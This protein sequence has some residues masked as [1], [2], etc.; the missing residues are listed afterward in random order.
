MYLGAV[1]RKARQ[2]WYLN[3]PHPVVMLLGILVVVA[4]LSYVLPAGEY[5][6][7]LVAGR[8]RVVPGSFRFVDARPVGLLTLFRALPEGFAKAAP[9]VYVI[10]ASGIM[11]G[12]VEQTGAIERAVC[13]LIRSVG[14]ARRLQVLV[15]T[16]FVYGMLGVFVGYEN[17]I[18]MVPIAAVLVLA[19]GGDLL[20]A[21]GVSVGAITVGFGVSPFNPY[22]VGIGHQLAQLP[23]FSGWLLRAALCL[24]S[25]SLLA[26]WNVRYLQ[27]ILA[28]PA[29]SLADGIDSSGFRL[30]AELASY[31]LTGRDGLILISFAGGLAV[32]LYGV[33]AQQWFLDE[34]SAVFVMT[35]IVVGIVGG[36]GPTHLAETSL[37]S[38]AVVA[39]GAFLVGLAN[40]VRVVMEAG[41]IGDT[42]TY[43]LAEALKG[44]APAVAA[45]GM[46]MTQSLTNFLIPSGSG[47]ALATLPVM[48][49]LGDLVGISRQVTVLAFQIG[50]GITN[51][52]NPTLG[53]LVAMLAMCRVPFD[54]W[55]RYI[56]PL[57]LIL[58]LVCLVVLV[59]SVWF[60][61][62]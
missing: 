26:W 16:T 7:E 17:N 9:V 1:T 50:D 41:G 31:R 14:E 53:G 58:M 33:F 19:L 49:P 55:L 10:F 59:A 24:L 42:I 38:V 6:R 52:L 4:G 11:F 44:L 5:A 45:V 43:G 37:A 54:R 46:V 3:L 30:R 20:L 56:F 32:M 51:L 2:P 25:L 15:L 35:A 28:N 40:A 22:T 62:S 47:Q 23:I 39:P 48:I 13:T 21:A 27:K 8:E 60:G 61:Y 29:A 34:I 12:I 36:L 18:A 57:V